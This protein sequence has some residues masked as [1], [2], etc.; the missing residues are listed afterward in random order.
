MGAASMTT[1]DDTI[2]AQQ[3]NALPTLDEVEKLLTLAESFGIKMIAVPD[4]PGRATDLPFWTA[5][6][7]KAAGL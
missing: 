3:A 2:T 6:Q 7:L 5:A 4:R 1:H